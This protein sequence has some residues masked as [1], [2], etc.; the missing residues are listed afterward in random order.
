[1][2]LGILFLVSGL[3]FSCA[4]DVKDRIQ[5]DTGVTVETL[6]P[7]KYKLVA[8]AQA[9]SASIEEND[10]FKMQNTSCTAAKTLAARKLEELEPE[11]KNRQFFLEAKGTK[12]LDNGAYC[13]IT[14]HYELPVPK[15]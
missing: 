6:G 12:Y 9:S 15:K 2:K 8:I 11:Q 3:L 4:Q 1:M 10:T 13:E 7:H 14:Y 5:M